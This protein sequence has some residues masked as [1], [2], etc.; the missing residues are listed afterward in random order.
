MSAN[1]VAQKGRG[2]WLQTTDRTRAAHAERGSPWTARKTSIF[3]RMNSPRSRHLAFLK[4]GL[5]VIALIAAQTAWS[6]Y[7]INIDSLEHAFVHE[8]D[9]VKRLGTAWWLSR[10]PNTEV[11]ER[12]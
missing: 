12:Y 8:S 10:S 1:E 6:Q 2:H 4:H 11:A 3:G 9:A 5:I 7:N